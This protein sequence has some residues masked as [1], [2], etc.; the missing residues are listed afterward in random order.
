MRF[1]EQTPYT[2]DG[3][4]RFWV[5]MVESRNDPL[6]QGR[7]Q[8]RI[9]GFH[10]DDISLI[11]TE[12]LPWATP[13]NP[14][15][16][17]SV[18]GVGFSPTGMMEGTMVMGFWGDFPDCQNPIILGT[19]N[20]Q[21]GFGGGLF[22]SYDNSIGDLSDIGPGT[23]NPTGDGPKWLQI[24]RGELKKGVREIPGSRHNPEVLKYGRDLGFT[25]DDSSH[26]W[27]AAFVRWCLKESGVS[28]QGVTGGSKSFQHSP[29]YERIAQPLYG[30]VAVKNRAGGKPWQ[31]HAG[32]WVGRKAGKDLYIGGNQG[33]RVSIGAFSIHQHFGYFW[34]KGV[35]KNQAN[36][37]GSGNT[38]N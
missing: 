25:T 4:M 2:V 26:P 33:N 12:T 37:T 5:G 29:A 11:P 35:S 36:S 21:E 1:H 24:A 8:V 13:L 20:L 27:C 17:A 18:S 22:N 38:S 19:L 7:V 16:S 15:N 28:V 23:I 6:Q 31:G 10:T 32:F 14:I 34:P 30:C 3:T 9:E